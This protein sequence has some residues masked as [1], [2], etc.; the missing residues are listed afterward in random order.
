MLEELSRLLHF[1]PLGA[2][3]GVFPALMSNAFTL[4][5]LK[6]ESEGFFFFKVMNVLLKLYQHVF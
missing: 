4:M 6:L 1:S 3:H 2:Q 5:F